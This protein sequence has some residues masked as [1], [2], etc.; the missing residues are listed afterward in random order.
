[1]W[2]RLDALARRRAWLQA[3]AKTPGLAGLALRDTAAPG[4]AM[5]P[6]G[7]PR[8][9][10]DGRNDFGYTDA[11][12]LACLRA[13]GVDP[14]DIDWEYTTVGRTPLTLPFFDDLLPDGRRRPS[15]SAT[16]RTAWNGVRAKA[17]LAALAP[18]HAALAK[19]AP[20]GFPVWM[21]DR[22]DPVGEADLR[23]GWYGTWDRPD[24]PPTQT[25]ADP[26]AAA[27]GGAAGSPLGSARAVS[28][29]VLLN[30]TETPPTRYGPLPDGYKPD[31]VQ[32]FAR[33]VK[34]RLENAAKNGCWDGIVLDLS[35]MPLADALPLLA[36]LEE[37]K[38]TP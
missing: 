25:P 1:V 10:R 34:Y 24:A 6:K 16:L 21:R 17:N 5:P 13:E 20:A 33:T 8:D 3:L 36:A 38:T 30:L 4:Y 7:A 27:T 9:Q 18:L 14:V 23:G 37:T 29:R 19:T 11:L 31:R 26:F 28:K 32:D 35:E 2:L 12:R 15:S 22:V